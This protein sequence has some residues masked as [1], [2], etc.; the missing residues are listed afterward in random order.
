MKEIAMEHYLIVAAILFSIGLATTL[1]KRNA[2]AVLI[3]IELM[4]NAANINL[5]AFSRTDPDG[6]GQL[7]ALFVIAIAAA[8]VV[9][10]LTLVF[11]VYKHK[12]EADLNT[13]NELGET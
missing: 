3:G 6:E 2:I 1:V 9:V 11:L 8:E 10:G 13:Y 12:Q 7:L 5:V 4:L